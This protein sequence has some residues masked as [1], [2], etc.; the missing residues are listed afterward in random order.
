MK[1]TYINKAIAVLLL[2]STCM[3]AQAAT[4]TKAAPK[5]LTVQVQKLGDL[6]SDGYAVRFE[7]A[8]YFHDIR[9]KDR[10]KLVL[11]VFTMEGFGGGNNHGQFLAIFEENLNENNVPY[12]TYLDHIAIGGK[13][14]RGVELLNTKVVENKKN[15]ELNISFEALEVGENDAPN[16]PSKKVVVKV[17]YAKG[18]LVEIGK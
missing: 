9:L 1:Q 6:I 16:F 7:G 13:G 2:S 4:K 5:E 14:W 18:E 17:V 3:F 10:N 12:Y 8:T 11:S 15:N